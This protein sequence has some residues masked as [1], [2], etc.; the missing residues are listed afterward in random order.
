MG[1]TPTT[2]KPMMDLSHTE[3]IRLQ[4]PFLVC[5]IGQKSAFPPRARDALSEDR[6]GL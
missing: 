2:K 1:L 6:G 5:V 3:K 4:F